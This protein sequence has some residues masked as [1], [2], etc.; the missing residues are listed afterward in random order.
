MTCQSCSSLG[1]ANGPLS[2]RDKS[3]RRFRRFSGWSAPILTLSQLNSHPTFAF[4]RICPQGSQEA[5]AFRRRGGWGKLFPKIERKEQSKT[6]KV[7]KRKRFVSLSFSRRVFDGK[8]NSRILDC[9]VKWC[10]SGVSVVLSER[11]GVEHINKEK[12][13]CRAQEKAAGGDFWSHYMGL[14]HKLKHSL[15][16][17]YNFCPSYTFAWSGL[18]KN[19][20]NF[21][22][23]ISQFREAVDSAVVYDHKVEDIFQ[24]VH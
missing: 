23:S 10:F 24:T 18:A 17:N 16:T 9:R 12:E 11:K 22:S 3:W 8:Q 2:G 21:A 5:M 4:K 15:V 1:A 20:C 6:L 14:I 13:G 19:I 7:M